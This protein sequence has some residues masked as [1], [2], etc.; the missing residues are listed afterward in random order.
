MAVTIITDTTSDVPQDIAE[1]LGIRVLPIRIFF[2]DKEYVE[3]VNLTKKDFFSML[4]ECEKLPSTTQITP[5]ELCDYFREYLD[6]GDE[7][8]CML[9]SAELSGTHNNAFIAKD[10]LKD[11]GG[12]RI[13]IVDTKNVTF[14]LG[15]LVL[16]AARLLATGNYTAPELCAEMNV[17][18]KK[19]RLYGIMD[20]LKYLKLN[21]RLSGTAAFLGTILNIKPIVV[22]DDGKVVSIAKTKG[23]QKGC[24]FVLAQMKKHPVDL[25][26][27]IGFASS[28]STEMLERIISDI[29][30]EYPGISDFARFEVGAVVGAHI[31]PRS[32]AVAYFERD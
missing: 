3:G 8:V 18:R 19:V 4:A 13:H 31:G 30:K 32:A 2:G 28:N 7:I 25:E 16:E 20:T 26:R 22:I 5:G 14:G 27:T 21:G 12:E 10:M 17:L 29:T 23:Y 15:V 24:K 1:R 6:R 9:I 11:Q